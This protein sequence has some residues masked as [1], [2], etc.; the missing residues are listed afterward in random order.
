MQDKENWLQ[1]KV[2]KFCYQGCCYGKNPLKLGN[3]SDLFQC[4][5]EMHFD[6]NT[7]QSDH[8]AV[9]LVKMPI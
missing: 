2:W 4:Y 3:E 6:G 7:K 1:W 5:T 9:E 8:N